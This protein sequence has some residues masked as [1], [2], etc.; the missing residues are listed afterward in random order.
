MLHLSWP[1]RY[2]LSKADLCVRQYVGAGS[3][4]WASYRFLPV[5]ILQSSLGISPKYYA[6]TNEHREEVGQMLWIK[7]KRLGKGCQVSGKEWVKCTARRIRFAWGYSGYYEKSAY[8][9][10]VFRM[11]LLLGIVT[12]PVSSGQG[13][14]NLVL[15]IVSSLIQKSSVCDTAWQ[16]LGLFSVKTC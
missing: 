16:L 3:S 4:H 2:S 9:P 10:R 7:K 14:W 15:A 13:E 12:C 1:R 5:W 6:N 8:D 11:Y